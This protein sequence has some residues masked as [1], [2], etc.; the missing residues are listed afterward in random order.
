MLESFEK[1]PKFNSL[2]HARYCASSIAKGRLPKNN[3]WCMA[4]Y[5]IA[6]IKKKRQKIKIKKFFS[7]F[8]S[9]IL[10]K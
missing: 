5:L 7:F 9:E 2:D 3:G 10:F 1:Y 4:K 8:L 6:N